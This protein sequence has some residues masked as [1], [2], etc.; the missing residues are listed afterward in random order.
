VPVDGDAMARGAYVFRAADCLSCHT[1]SKN[2]GQPLA[3]GRALSTPF[4]TFYTPNIT[5]DATHGL[6]R[7]T[8][9]DFRRALRQGLAPYGSHF[10]PAFPYPSYA[11]MTDGDISDLWAYLQTQ[12]AVAQGNRRHD[13]ALPFRFRALI[14]VWKALFFKPKPFV[15]E[16]DQDAVWTRGAYLVQVLGHCGECHTPRNLLG[17]PK[18]S[19]HLAGAAKGPDGKKV[20]NITPFP[21][22]GIGDWRESDITYFLKTGFLPDGDVA[23]AAM[24]EVIEDGTSHLTNAD[25]AAIALYLRSLPPLPSP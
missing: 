10:Y 7:W 20:P 23:G 11:G 1:D 18:T 2:K 4:G 15:A 9:E 22:T 12:P 25:R 24:A 6:G 14:G 8:A 5:P 19:R 13:L 16:P 17:G 3:G 21:K